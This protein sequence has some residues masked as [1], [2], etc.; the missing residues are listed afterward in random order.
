MD[1]KTPEE[2]AAEEQEAFEKKVAEKAAKDQALIDKACN[3]Y[4]IESK[5]LFASSIKKGVVTILTNGGK[6]VRYK[7]G[8]KVEKL[9]DIAITGIN[10]ELEKRKVIAGKAKKEAK[11]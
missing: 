8:D 1:P 4:G 2:I 5:Y 9:G 10:P 6:R 11:G 7:P 3:A